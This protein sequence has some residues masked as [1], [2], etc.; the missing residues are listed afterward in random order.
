M[1]LSDDERAAIIVYRKQ[2]AYASLQE[3]EDVAK[4]NHWNLVANRLYYACYYI[5][6]ALL[7]DRKFKAQSHSGVVHLIGLHF[8]TKGLLAREY[9]R[10]FSRL[11]E[12]RQSGDYDDLFDFS[13]EEVLPYFERTRDFIREIERLLVEQK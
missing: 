5:A 11:Y 6:S 12:M 1:K 7:I 10:L 4:F 9:G 2:K 8:V 3:A 13:A